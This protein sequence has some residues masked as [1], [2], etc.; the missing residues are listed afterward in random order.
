MEGIW[1]ISFQKLIGLSKK[2]PIHEYQQRINDQAG[3][4]RDSYVLDL[5]DSSF[6]KIN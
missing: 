3:N 4:A 1:R 5:R 6:E 2:S